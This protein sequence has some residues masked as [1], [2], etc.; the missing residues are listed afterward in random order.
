DIPEGLRA[1]MEP[2]LR[3][4]GPRC[5]GLPGDRAGGLPRRRRHDLQHDGRQ[6]VS[7]GPSSQL[8]QQ[9]LA[10]HLPFPAIHH[11]QWVPTVRARSTFLSAGA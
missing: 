9:P 8:N 11:H 6:K 5:P 2:E 4:V 3:R 10:S 1:G 7:A